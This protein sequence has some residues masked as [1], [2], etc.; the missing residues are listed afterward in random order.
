MSLFHIK[1]VGH[2]ITRQSL[3]GNYFRLL[4]II[5]KNIS[6]RYKLWHT[7]QGLMYF[8][9]LVPKASEASDGDFLFLQE[10]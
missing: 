4:V 6:T 7:D 9:L 5:L 8:F 2:E 3:I 1:E 10:F